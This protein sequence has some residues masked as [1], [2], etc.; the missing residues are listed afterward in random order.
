MYETIYSNGTEI[1]PFEATMIAEELQEVDNYAD[2]IKS[3]SYL[4]G[5]K[6]AYSLQ[7]WFGRQARHMIEAR[8]IQA[9]GTV[10]WEIVNSK[11]HKDD[12]G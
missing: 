4:I 10:N 9:D 1:S 11:I 6:I 3:W 2:Y 7:G 12:E 5:T 8:F